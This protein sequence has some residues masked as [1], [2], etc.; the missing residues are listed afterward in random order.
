MYAYIELPSTLQR[1]AISVF[2]VTVL[3]I[4]GRVGTPFFCSFFPEKNIILCILKGI[5]P[6]KMQKIIYFFQ[7]TWK[8]SRFHQKILVGWS[9]PKHRIFF[10]RPYT[11][12][13]GGDRKV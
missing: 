6:L 7:K 10:I 2:R 12:L 5:S 11:G 8:K 4:L 3:K 13:Y 9:Y 1:N